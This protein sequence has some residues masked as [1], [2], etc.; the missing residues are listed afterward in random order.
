MTMTSPPRDAAAVDSPLPVLAA[1]GGIGG[2]LMG[3]ANLVPGVS[4]GTMLLAAGVYPN[5]VKAVAE[6][7]TLK[8]RLR[9]IIL[10]GSV[11]VA[12]LL[13]IVLL[14]GPVKDLVVNQRWIMYSLFIG[15][16]LGGV[17]LIWR[18]L[19]GLET[20]AIIGC[21]VGFGLMGV[22]AF[23]QPSDA[24][25]THE[26]HP[27]LLYFL[28]GL[29]GASA[30]V[31]PGV[32]G[33]YLLLVL[34]QYVTI[35]AAISAV[36]DAA[37]AGDFAA[38]SE[39]LHVIVPVGIGVILGVVGVSNLVRWLLE[40]HRQ[41]T[42][43]GLLGLLLGAVLGLWPYQQGVAPEVGS[44]FKG[45]IVARVGE[46]L[47][48]QTTGKAISPEVFPT[49]FFAPNTTQM[50]VAPAII[51]AGFIASVLLSKIGGSE[52]GSRGN[53]AD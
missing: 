22:L 45:D 47:V 19:E 15:L 49:E 21:I 20:R 11:V 7:T 16:T 31:L 33:G 50:L 36:K 13:A 34:G 26:G 5:F 39:T 3:L 18:M 29:A 43:G 12:A 25:A 14:A 48:M 10:L 42:L 51:F 23:V 37:R 44:E 35:L 32:S 27:Y 38:A 46:Q 53:S 1:R 41:I 24:V 17:P 30:M 4:G 40:H 8:F 6:I 28:A 2:V 52:N 9:S